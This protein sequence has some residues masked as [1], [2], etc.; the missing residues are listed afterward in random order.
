MCQG[1]Q[2]EVGSPQDL[3]L[4]LS[5]QQPQA[6]SVVIGVCT[7]QRPVM[8]A[9]CLASLAVQRLPADVSARIIVV[10]NGDECSRKV[11]QA[12]FTSFEQVSGIPAIFRHSPRRGIAIARNVVLTEAMALNAG[13]VAFIDDDETA[14]P[15]WLA[16]LMA[17]RYRTTP[18]L[19]G[20]RRWQYPSSPPFWMLPDPEDDG[21]ENQPLP[22]ASTFNVRFSTELIRAGLRFDEALGFM[23]GE[24]TDFFAMARAKGFDIRRTMTAVTHERAHPERLTYAGQVYRAYWHSA[25]RLRRI[26]M[27]EGRRRAILSRALSVP[28]NVVYGVC[29]LAASPL[30][31]V[32]GRGA[33]KRRAVAG[34]KKIA[35]AIG[36]AAAMVGYLPRPYRT[37]VG[38]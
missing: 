12:A 2:L 7:S 21:F 18:V 28:A 9:A 37:V 30:F 10:H 17:P 20:T 29:E 19:M 33:F 26:A 25:S 32:G 5:T 31:I 27:L 16:G 34:G 3:S 35:K 4:D 1:R 15:D 24:D 13:W 6:Q 11:S 36:W 14:E 23:G 22:T 38:Q 8:L